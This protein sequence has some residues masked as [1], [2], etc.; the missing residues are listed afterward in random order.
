MRTFGLFIFLPFAAAAQTVPPPALVR[1]VI[2]ECDSQTA[3]GELAIRAADNQVFRYRFDAR[4][5]AERD[6]RLIPASRLRPGEKVEVVSDRSAA[7]AVRYA[8]TIHVVQPAAPPRPL[9]L[10]RYRATRND[11]TRNALLDLAPTGNLTFSAVVF[12]LN[13]ERAALHTREP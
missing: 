12:R 7:P 13:A 1:G 3:S 9:S 8:R 4:T 2:L 6:E 5:Y 11:P 10:G